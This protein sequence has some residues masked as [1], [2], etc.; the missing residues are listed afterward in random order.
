MLSQ[1]RLFKKITHIFIIIIMVAV[2]MT[3]FDN[4]DTEIVSTENILE[5][6]DCSTS[7]ADNFLNSSVN[8]FIIDEFRPSVTYYYVVEQSL[9][10]IVP[11]TLPYQHRPPPTMYQS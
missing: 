6:T 5:M 8:N 4:H 1:D 11:I 3:A 9:G 2:T 10:N 7:S